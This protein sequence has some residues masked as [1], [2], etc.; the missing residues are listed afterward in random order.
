MDLGIILRAVDQGECGGIALVAGS[1]LAS[2]AF[3]AEKYNSHPAFSRR[4]LDNGIL[5]L[6]PNSVMYHVS[7]DLCCAKNDV[8]SERNVDFRRHVP[9][10]LLL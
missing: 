2:G 1:I 7:R 8:G 10:D 3:K 6:Y 5:L 4:H 9:R